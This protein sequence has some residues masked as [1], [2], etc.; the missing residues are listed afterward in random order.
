MPEDISEKKIFR[1]PITGRMNP[2]DTLAFMELHARRHFKQI[3][4][5]LET[6]SSLS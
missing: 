1:H 3:K 4:E 5:I 6:Q 2:E